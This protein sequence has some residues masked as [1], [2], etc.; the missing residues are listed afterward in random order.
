M[1]AGVS[2]PESGVRHGVGQAG[3]VD[4]EGG[5]DPC[6]PVC[7]WRRWR[8]GCVTGAVPSRTGSVCLRKRPLAELIVDEEDRGGNSDVFLLPA[9]MFLHLHS[10]GVSLTLDVV[11]RA[12]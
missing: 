12:L 11:L 1:E 2:C 4:V 7:V 3:W 10:S 6:R 8:F 5:R 9:V